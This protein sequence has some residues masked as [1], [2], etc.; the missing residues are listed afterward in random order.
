MSR[1]LLTELKQGLPLRMHQSFFNELAQQI[2]FIFSTAKETLQKQTK[3]IYRVHE[4][5]KKTKSVPHSVSSQV[6]GLR[7]SPRLK[8]Q[9]CDNTRMVED[10]RRWWYGAMVEW[11]LVR[12]HGPKLTPV[13]VSLSYISHEVTQDCTWALQKEACAITCCSLLRITCP[14]LSLTSY[15]LLHFQWGLS[16]ICMTNKSQCTRIWPQ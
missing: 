6:W 16:R 11:W 13:P 1:P 3:N 14:Q 5:E 2:K 7:Q 12:E 4:T 15:S 8:E 10:F 9:I